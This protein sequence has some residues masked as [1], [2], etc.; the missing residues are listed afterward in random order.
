MEL[1][2]YGGKDTE[3]LSL[4]VFVTNYFLFFCVWE[5]KK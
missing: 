2:P 3:D 5:G 1:T 4:G